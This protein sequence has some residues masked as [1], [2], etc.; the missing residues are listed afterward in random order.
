MTNAMGSPVADRPLRVLLVEDNP[1]DIRLVQEMVR[2]VGTGDLVLTPVERLHQALEHLAS[3]GFD[4]VLLDLALPDS[5][6]METFV[7][8]HTHSPGIPIVVLTGLTDELL[9]VQA[10]REGAQDYL[11]KGKVD[12]HFLVHAVRYAIERKRVEGALRQSEARFRALIESTFDGYVIH[13]HGVIVD[14]NR[15]FAQM[16]GYDLS[17]V[18]GKRITDFVPEVERGSVTERLRSETQ[19][20]YETVGLRKDGSVFPVE[21]VARTQANER[22]VVRVAGVRDISVRRRLEQ[23]LLRSQKMEAIGRL[24]GGVAHDFNNLL[25]AIQSSAELLL[26]E[27]PADDPQREE[28]EEIRGAVNR[29]ADLARQL[30]AFSRPRPPDPALLDLNQV[31]TGVEK[32]LRRVIGEQVELVTDLAPDAGAIAADRGEIEQVLL[33]LAVNARDAMPGGGRL[34]IATSTVEAGATGGAMDVPDGSGRYAVLTVSDTGIGM[35]EETQARLF[36]P[37]FTTKEEGKGT[38]LG[39]AMVYSIVHGIGGHISVTSEL[40]RG[41]AFKIFLRGAQA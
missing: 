9:A 1:A 10:V 40:G 12:G 18:V 7:R 33:N 3:E 24:A 19:E 8:T 39:L 41:T 11:V 22:G 36:E 13:E 5:I 16:F 35:D 6:G 34:T 25:T 38:G 4:A 15:G 2:E 27:N 21:A 14:A 28:L 17:E 26:L 32:L 23:Q 29:G 31:V 37:F 30:L 20:Q